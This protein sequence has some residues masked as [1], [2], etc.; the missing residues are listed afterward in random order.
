MQPYR[1][2]NKPTGHRAGALFLPS[3]GPFPNKFFPR[4]LPLPS[5]SFQDRFFSFPG[6]QKLS[7]YLKAEF[8]GSVLIPE[9]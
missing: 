4:I 1:F 5:N 6:V 2:I 9:R 3:V 8:M 7:K